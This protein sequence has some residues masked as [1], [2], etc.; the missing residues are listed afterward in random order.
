M[1]ATD[2]DRYATEFAA[3]TARLGSVV[4]EAEPGTPLPTCPGW[5]IRDLVTHV[6]TGHRWAAEIVARSDQDPPPYA[7]VDAP[8]D[9]ATWPGWLA[10]GAAELVA[11]IR[12]RGP[13]RHAWTWQQQDST[14]GFWLRKMLH[15]EIVH[16]FDVELALHHHRDVG[17]W[18]V[19]GDTGSGKTTFAPISRSS[20][21]TRRR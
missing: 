16:R 17:H 12:A 8:Q 7:I 10:A 13:Q 19:T 11:A 9:P 2:E 6:G 20:T 15:D 14:A 3:E 1:F 5:T 21:A 18:L 4:T